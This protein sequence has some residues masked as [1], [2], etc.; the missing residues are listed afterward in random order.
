MPLNKENKPC[1]SSIDHQILWSTVIKF[2]WD[3]YF[4][5]SSL[6]T[7]HLWFPT[8]DCKNKKK[9]SIKLLMVNLQ[10]IKS[11]KVWP[12]KVKFCLYFAKICYQAVNA[13][14]DIL[15]WVT[16]IIYAFHSKDNRQTLW[17][18]TVHFVNTKHHAFSIVKL[19]SDQDIYHW[20]VPK[21]WIFILTLW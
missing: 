20:L 13:E 4:I 9:H 7:Y 1:L 17:I 12:M 18:V 3:C 5:F 14:L 6:Y 15:H 11:L 10:I 2:V 21:F 19:Y 8:T 16:L